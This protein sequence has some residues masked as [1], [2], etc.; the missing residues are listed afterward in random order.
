MLRMT[1][2]IDLSPTFEMTVSILK[3]N[4]ITH[5]DSVIPKK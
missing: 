3:H 5:H 1:F 4:S 2:L